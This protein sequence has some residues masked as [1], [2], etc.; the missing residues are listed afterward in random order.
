MF[1]YYKEIFSKNI[2][3]VRLKGNYIKKY[4]KFLSIKLT[5]IIH[6]NNNSFDSVLNAKRN[7]VKKLKD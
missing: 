2:I 7:T 6:E 4:E 1:N 5:K 3:N